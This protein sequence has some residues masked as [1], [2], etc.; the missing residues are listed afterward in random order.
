MS[1]PCV[2]EEV[3]NSDDMIRTRKR[4]LIGIFLGLGF[5]E[6][7]CQGRAGCRDAGV[8]N[9]RLALRQRVTALRKR[10]RRPPAATIAMTA[11]LVIRSPSASA[12]I[13]DRYQAMCAVGHAPGAR[14]GKTFAPSSR[15]RGDIATSL[16]G[17]IAR[18]G[19][20]RLAGRC[21]TAGR[22]LGPRR[23]PCGTTAL[24]SRA[25]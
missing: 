24:G 7:P 5:R 16:L 14:H 23:L 11:A 18:S 1:S 17:L 12:G 3:T 8:R 21:R 6:Q 15:L 4:P 22:A 2:V 20:S 19:P 13:N 25:S 10:E 9:N